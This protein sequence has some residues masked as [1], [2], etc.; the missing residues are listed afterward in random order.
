MRN[1]F[2]NWCFTL[3]NYDQDDIKNLIEEFGTS[4]YI[5]QEEKGETEHLQGAVFMKNAIEFSSVKKICERAHW[6]KCNNKRAAIRYCQKEDT[7]NGKI[8]HSNDIKI[9]KALKDPMQELKLRDWQIEINQM[10]DSEPDE[11]KIYWFWEEE[12]KVGKTSFAKHLCM[13]KN[14]LYLSG[15]SNDIKYSIAQF[16]EKND[17]EI[18]IFDLCRSLEDYVSYE[19]IESIKNGIFY[20]GK[21]E[22]KMVLFNSPH[23]IIFANFEPCYNKLSRD[24]WVVKNIEWIPSPPTLIRSPPL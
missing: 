10:I 13:K 4:S 24:R 18:A 7:R 17:L 1:R 19:A 16:I 20:S 23:V 12:G 2:R 15:K 6:E 3:N 21:Y 22:S 8:Y 11:R 14:A 9:R 5:F